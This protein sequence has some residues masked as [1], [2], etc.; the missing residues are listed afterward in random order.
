LVTVL[1]KVTE[2]VNL[3]ADPLSHTFSGTIGLIQD[4]KTGSERYFK[5]L[6]Y[7]HNFASVRRRKSRQR[8]WPGPLDCGPAS[9]HQIEDQG[10]EGQQ[11]QNVDKAP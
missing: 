7:V 11:Q 5:K 6:L 4:E 10:Y 9:T 1:R 8:S 2:I 3:V